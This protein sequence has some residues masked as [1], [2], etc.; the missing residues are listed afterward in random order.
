MPRV[1]ADVLRQRWPR[2]LESRLVAGTQWKGP[3]YTD[4]QPTG[5]I[6]TGATGTVLQPRKADMYF[7]SVRTRAGLDA[8]KFHGLRHD[9]RACFWPPASPIAL[10]W[11]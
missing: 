3:D 6:F 5:F 11:R 7:A 4:S 1:V 10:S 8:H 2:Q 9:S